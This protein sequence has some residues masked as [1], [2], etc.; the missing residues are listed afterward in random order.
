MPQQAHDTLPPQSSQLQALIRDGWEQEV[1]SQLPAD[2]E[3]RARQLGAFVRV[4]GLGCV[5]DLLRGLL[6]YVLCAPSLRHLGSWAVLIGLANLSHVAWHKRLRRARAFLLWLLSDLL[7]VPA[8]PAPVPAPRIVLVDATRL[9]E[10]GGTGDDW[11][12][13]LGY[14]LLAGRLLDVKVSDQH[15]AEGFTLFG[16]QVGDIVV[17]DRGYCRRRQLVFVLQ[18]GAQV[19]VRLAVHQVPLLDEHGQPLDVLAW[20]KALEHG[21]QRCLVAFEHEGRCFAGRLIACSLPVEAAERARAKERKKAAKQQRQLKAETLYLCGWLLLF[22]SLPAHRWSDEQVLALYRA[23]WQVE[24][25]IKRMK[26]VLRLAQLRGQTACTNEATLLALLVGWAL[27]QSATQHARQVLTQAQQQWACSQAACTAVTD[28]PVKCP[29]TV[30]SWTVTALTV[31]TLRLLVQ[32]SWTF[33]RLRSCLPYLQR[34]LSS[35]RRQRGHQESAIRRQLL[36][37]L[38][39]ADLDSAL[40]FSCSSA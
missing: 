9:K 8:Y 40:V 37:H 33:A 27:Q 15:T 16:W 24:L 13:H 35:R 30:S 7:A 4:R 39:Q 19:V 20:L 38:G 5:A 1:L 22:T 11:R 3:Q 10:P 25:V 17:A 32:G 6:A 14:D 28:Q 12:V 23:R 18:A 2:Y 29:P 26:Q 31:Q 34:F 36:V 21:Q